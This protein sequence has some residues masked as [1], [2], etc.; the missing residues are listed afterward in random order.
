MD[1]TYYE[2]ILYR[3][4]QGRLRLPSSDP[5]LYIHEPTADIIEQSYDVYKEFYDDAYFSGVYIK[6]ELKE[7]LFYNEIWSPDDDT[8]AESTSDQIEELKVE[9]Y[10]NY[11]NV[12]KLRGIKANIK[13]LE[14]Q[15]SKYKS[16][17]HTLDHISCEGVANFARS[18][19]VISK[20]ICD[21]HGNLSNR[22][23]LTKALEIYNS[24]AISAAE[25][26]YVA[27]NDPFRT[28]WNVGKKQSNVFGVAA[29]QL[30]R[31]QLQLCQYSSMYDNVQ[32]SHESPCE[33][34]INDDECLDGWFIVQKREH[35]KSRN[36][37]EIDKMLNNS[38]IANSQEVYLMAK[39]QQTAKKIDSMN[40]PVAKSVINSRNQQIDEAGS[41]KFTD[42]HDVRQDIA[43]QQRQ[44]AVNKIKGR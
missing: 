29:C 14:K 21:E 23:P 33:E 16:K 20:T 7:I 37:R 27:R 5:V 24:K 22:I 13:Y 9:A 15:Y 8:Q 44:A 30:T 1:K 19:W 12:P 4:I 36:K 6:E 17:F 34:V 38:K 39:D 25:Y 42:L 31:D 10:K 43:I 28:M 32:E 26:R 2:N 40:N 11:Y 18:I 3:I 41:L 35:E